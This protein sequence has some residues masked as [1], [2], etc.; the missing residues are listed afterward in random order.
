MFCCHNHP[1]PQSAHAT[2]AT[3]LQTQ[4][5][6][7][8]LRI[9]FTLVARDHKHGAAIPHRP[10]HSS[11]AYLQTNVSMWMSASSQHWAATSHILIHCSMQSRTRDLAVHSAFACVRIRQRSAN[12]VLTYRIYQ[13]LGRENTIYK[14]R[15][16][17]GL[18]RLT[19]DC[20]R[21][22]TCMHA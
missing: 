13:P 9:D 11:G 18:A 6:D 2:H 16:C 21:A 22:G 1:G 19:H 15:T 14:W 3:H 4:E 8:L 12:F 5:L 17:A 7:H 10:A 20:S